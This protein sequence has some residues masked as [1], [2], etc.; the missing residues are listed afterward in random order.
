MNAFE[1]RSLKYT[2]SCPETDFSINFA[3]MKFT[4][5]NL[6]DMAPL[7]KKAAKGIAD[8][9]SG[10]IKNPDEKRKVTHFTDRIAYAESKLFQEVEAFAADIRSGKIT[11][12]TGKKFDAVVINGIAHVI[13]PGGP[14]DFPWGPT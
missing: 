5:K 6:D 11:G 4:G 12:A 2:L 8:I 7:F 13:S 1:K 10:K 14:R 9:E 3:G